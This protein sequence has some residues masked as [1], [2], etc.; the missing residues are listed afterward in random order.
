MPAEAM[1]G[2]G[3]H[4]PGIDAPE[5][6]VVARLWPI[7]Y[8]G[9]AR[10]R[11]RT[12]QLPKRLQPRRFAEG[13]WG[14]FAWKAS[15]GNF[16]H[17]LRK[18]RGERKRRRHVWWLNLTAHAC[19]TVESRAERRVGIV[20]SATLK[21]DEIIPLVP[22]AHSVAADSI[23]NRVFVPLGAGS[24]NTICPHGCTGIYRSSD[25]Q[26]SN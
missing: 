17:D 26:A 7:S 3:G 25:Q 13:L 12:K 18:R 8:V 10:A 5:G 2:N 24:S 15:A 4:R 22:G 1:E 21:F 11:A 9:E 23:S 14:P 19:S 16:Y 6:G 20:H